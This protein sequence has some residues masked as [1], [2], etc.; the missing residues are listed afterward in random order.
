MGKMAARDQTRGKSTTKSKVVTRKPGVGRSVNRTASEKDSYDQYNL[1]EP[2][3]KKRLKALSQPGY[4]KSEK[5][6][7]GTVY[8][9]KRK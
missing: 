5:Y 8:G 6:V 9:S 1:N 2:R 4:N 7:S 3:L